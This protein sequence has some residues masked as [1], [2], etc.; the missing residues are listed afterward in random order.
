MSLSWCDRY[1]AVLGASRVGLC[2]RR[3]KEVEW[4]GSSGF[5]GDRQPAWSA[6]LEA[7]E[8]LLLERGSSRAELQVVLS[9][10][11]TRICLVPWR[12]QISSTGELQAYARMCF[13]DIYGA[14]DDDWLLRLSPEA[15]GMP[16]LAAAIPM[17]LVQGT[18]VLAAACGLRLISVQP[19]LMAAFNRF[20]PILKESDFLFVLAEP[21]RSTL[22]LVR[23]GRWAGVRCVTGADSDA[24]LCRLITRECELRRDD[25]EPLQA[26]YLHAPGRDDD[27][28]DCDCH[29]VQPQPLSLPLPK[30][31]QRDA[32][33]VMAQAVS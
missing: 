13:D 1:I 27:L 6:A 10:V 20:G 23:S 33:Y 26:V 16:R 12:E 2:R 24:A 21:G 15:E 18:G 29:E 4:L 9:S 7:L 17:P 3:G 32:L 31:A 5:D 19:Y 25:G 8:Q 30:L 28:P 22:L 11:H 14:Q